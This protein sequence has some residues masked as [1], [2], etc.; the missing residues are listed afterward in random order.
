MR[1]ILASLLAASLIASMSM[2]ALALETDADP[3]DGKPEA[4][5]TAKAAEESGKDVGTSGET[6]ETKEDPAPDSESKESPDDTE[7]TGKDKP[8]TGE[9]PKETEEAK[10]SAAVTDKTAQEGVAVPDP[11]VTAAQEPQV[12]LALEA[13]PRSG[14]DVHDLRNTSSDSGQGGSGT[15][16]WEDGTLTLMNCTLNVSLS[17]DYALFMLP[18]NA[19][20]EVMMGNSITVTGGGQAFHC[21]GDVTFH[22]PEISDAQMGAPLKIKTD[23]GANAIQA[24][25]DITCETAPL[26]IA[27]DGGGTGMLATGDIAL[28]GSKVSV[29]LGGSSKKGHGISSTGGNVAA[30]GGKISVSGSANVGVN[31]IND[32]TLTGTDVNIDLTG[33]HGIFSE[34]GVTVSGGS[35]ITIDGTLNTAIAG[36][37]DGVTID[38]SD[39][40]VTVNVPAN[41]SLTFA[42]GSNGAKSAATITGDGTVNLSG[43]VNS[44]YLDVDSGAT[45]AVGEDQELEIAANS[46]VTNDGTLDVSG[47]VSNSGTIANNGTLD[48]GGTVS[49]NGKIANEGTISTSGT[50]TNGG[51]IENKGKI[52]LNDGATLENNKTI[53]NESGAS[54]ENK[55]GA[56]IKNN[57]NAS[58]ENKDGAE[59][60]NNGTI[61]TDKN[62]TINNN[63]KIETVEGGITG[64][65]EISGIE[66]ISPVG[67]TP[68]PT[69]ITPP[70]NNTGGSSGSGGGGGGSS[71]S[72]SASVFSKLTSTINSILKGNLTGG[73]SGVTVKASGQGSPVTQ[74][75]ANR[76]VSSGVSQAKAQNKKTA[77]VIFSNATTV[78]V[79]V[80]ASIASQAQ[81]SGLEANVVMDSMNGNAVG[82]RV[83]VS[84]GAAAQLGRELNLSAA[85]GSAAIEK[86]FAKYYRNKIAV[87]AMAQKGSFGV[88]VDVAARVDLSGMDTAKLHFYTYDAAANAYREIPQTNSFIDGSG[89]L[90]FNT[91]AGNNIIISEGDLTLR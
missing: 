69:P 77:D 34:T 67:P 15:W 32:V 56:S 2:S 36:D 5:E 85:V 65:G 64:D 71:G 1:K 49:N 60:K 38:T 30:S 14:S 63:G 91:S 73:A 24:N 8:E 53:T 42:N 78:P 66:P 88:P 46:K 3:A 28:N 90:H 76:A 82:V 16:H 83:R 4:G 33:D 25:G 21:A 44:T 74:A 6:N 58:I 75:M 13:S 55:D 19:T 40:D 29:N 59:I 68:P 39:G 43:K 54:I 52:E 80:M 7:E 81:K 86:H 57:T 12:N 47:T 20:V 62:A 79:D 84:A 89:Y 18:A 35:N 50:V 11:S 9:T 23:N 51:D 10:D 31:A 61:E 48:A 72:K 37:K 45:V 26:A 87:V 70:A 17:S 22:C 27:V 41:A